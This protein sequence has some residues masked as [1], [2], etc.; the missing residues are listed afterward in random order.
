[1]SAEAVPR[2]H[3]PSSCAAP[4][5]P[6]SA[7]LADVLDDPVCVSRVHQGSGL[8]GPRGGTQP[9]EAIEPRAPRRPR[10]PRHRMPLSAGSWPSAV[11]S[12][13]SF[14]VTSTRPNAWP[15]SRSQLGNE[16]GQP[17]PMGIYAG[18]LDQ[19]PVP[20]GPV[21][22]AGAH[23]GPGGSRAAQA[24]GVPGGARGGVHVRRRPDAPRRSMPRTARAASPC[25]LTAM[26]HRPAARGPMWRSVSATGP[27]PRSSSTSW[28]RSTTTM[29]FTTS[30]SSRP[31]RTTSAPSTTSSTGTTTPTAGS[32]E[33]LTIHQRMESPLL[34]TYTQAA[35]ASL[36]AD[37]DHPDDPTHA[38]DMAHHALA[39][40][41]ACG[42][43]Y[44]AGTRPS[45]A[46]SQLT[47]SRG[48]GCARCRSRG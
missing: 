34:V 41:T 13:R 14:A 32:E 27:R 35:W 20:P 12:T 18:Q 45:P 6:N 25:A 21:C 2:A 36:L 1:M 22:R 43:G 17:D 30:R 9:D 5:P 29:P 48:R 19:R 16:T 10:S 33:A 23:G 26:D 47:T 44:I 15:I 37:R 8:D 3:R 28:R 42:F 7:M 39:A 24:S 46:T 4:G 38:R 11:S 40:A 31:W